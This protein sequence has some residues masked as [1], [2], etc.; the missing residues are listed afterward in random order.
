MVSTIQQNEIL[1]CKFKMKFA[2]FKEWNQMK[3]MKIYAQQLNNNNNNCV[4][5]Y[6]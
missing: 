2:H 6:T 3:K 1:K 4:S 5:D